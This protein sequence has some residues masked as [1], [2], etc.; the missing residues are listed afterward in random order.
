M[1][2]KTAAT[3]QDMLCE[4]AAEFQELVKVKAQAVNF[5][6]LLPLGFTWH[7]IMKQIISL[8]HSNPVN[9]NW[10]IRIMT[11]YL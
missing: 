3:F 1:E 7:S 2:R 11:D 4:A 6:D 5:S 8:T 9:L 10:T